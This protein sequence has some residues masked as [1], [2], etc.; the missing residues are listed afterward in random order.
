MRLS[1]FLLL[2]FC[3][4][5]FLSA[6][7]E[8]PASW[9]TWKEETIHELPRISG[10]C[11][12]EKAEKIMEFLYQARPMTCV[13]IGTFGG[14]TTYPIVR[15]LQYLGKGSVWAVDA[16]DTQKALE[17]LIPGSQAY[18]WWSKIDMNGLLGECRA[19]L[20]YNG[21]SRRCHIVQSS[22]QA[23]L[24]SLHD[25]SIDFIYL[26]GT[27]SSEGCLNDA[28]LSCC[29]VK[30]GGYIWLNDS[31]LDT[32]L[33]AVAYLMDHCTWIEEYSLTNRSVLFQKE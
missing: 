20:A 24:S 14:A 16:W 31:N 6:V 9:S 23:F 21:L 17:G 2:C 13:E 5:I 4:P 15:S 27:A 8:Q 22:S 32:R 28:L 12:R 18:I 29:K 25:D 19:L 1:I 30:K 7:G 3:C 10:W 26:D 11:S 33:D